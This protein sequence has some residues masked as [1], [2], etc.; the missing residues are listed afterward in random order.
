M[1]EGFEGQGTP[2]TL[3]LLPQL[4][5]RLDVGTGWGLMLHP[6]ISGLLVHVQLQPSPPPLEG[7]M[8]GG[9]L[10]PPP[11]AVSGGD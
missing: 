4:S 6:C 10:L 3:L 9:D 5:L 2:P 11:R 8:A 7:V 1:P